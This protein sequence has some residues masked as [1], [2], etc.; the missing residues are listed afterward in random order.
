MDRTLLK[1]IARRCLREYTASQADLQAH[2]EPR[3]YSVAGKRKASGFKIRTS[4][5][6]QFDYRIGPGQQYVLVMIG[7]KFVS[8]IVEKQINIRTS[9][10]LVVQE[11][12]IF[13]VSIKDTK[14]EQGQLDQ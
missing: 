6:R 1:K 14:N 12:K 8:I 9:E 4:D 7:K 2:P 3:V 11:P 10:G 5:W 13:R